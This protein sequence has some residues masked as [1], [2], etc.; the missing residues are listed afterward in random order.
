[1]HLSLLLY[2]KSNETKSSIRKLPLQNLTLNFSFILYGRIG[3]V[4]LTGWSMSHLPSLSPYFVNFCSEIHHQ[5]QYFLK[6]SLGRLDCQ[7]PL[8]IFH[9]SSSETNELP[10]HTSST[11]VEFMSN[12]PPLSF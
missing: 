7:L 1:M 8:S 11:N 2:L 10:T 5:I 12:V 3:F 9:R 6:L 4:H